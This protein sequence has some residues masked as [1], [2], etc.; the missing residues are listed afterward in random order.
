MTAGLAASGSLLQACAPKAA[1]T[2]TP[3]TTEVPTP[4]GP[5]RGGNLVFATT[6]ATPNL[7]PQMEISDARMRRSPLMYDTLVEWG[8]DFS[9][10]PGL[11]ESWDTDGNT[12]T[13][14]LR[15]GMQ[16]SNGKELDAEDVI[17]SM[18]RVLKSPGAGFYGG[19]QSM[20]AVDKHTVQFELDRPSAPLMAALGG[21][22]AFILPKGAAEEYNLKQEAVG[23][24]AFTVVEFVQDQRLVLE[25]NPNYWNADNVY[26]DALTIQ[27]I[28]DETSIIAGLRAGEIH[29][30]IFE[31]SKNYLLVKDDPNLV[32]QRWPA[33]RWSVLDFPLDV[34]PYSNV[35]LRQAIASALDREA[36]MQAAIG[37]LGSHL[38]V[39]PPALWPS[40]PPEKHPFFKRDVERGKQL[41]AEAGYPD[42]LDLTL[43]GIVGY[44]AL[45]AAAQVIAEN[46]KDI[47]LNVQI[48]QQELGIWIDEFL[49]GT[50]DNFTMNAWGGWIDPDMPLYNHFHVPP[51]GKDFR[52]WGNKEIS[53]LLDQG[54]FTLAREK[55]EEI[56]IKI[57]EI[58][59]EQ[60]PLVPL[61][62]ADMV[63]TQPQIVHNFTQHPSGYYHNLRWVWL[64]S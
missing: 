54:R 39:L 8:D 46:L 25:R 17:Y 37:G 32:A 18:E 24:G 36:I 44:S 49:A 56:Y 30:T 57:Q 27:I 33:A 64:E 50:F 7:D 3:T 4:T 1:P 22:Y 40:L 2:P 51:E 31:D 20:E 59:A 48:Q 47:G 28:P 26:L 43:I 61:F 52:G 53:E 45:N 38:Y 21:R 6:V 13:F 9:I 23:T 11:A 42:G 5:E 60:V 63:T 14:N 16:F 41:L 34:E 29:L 55:R 58:I 10:K 35:K 12:W 62:S 15:Q 19:I